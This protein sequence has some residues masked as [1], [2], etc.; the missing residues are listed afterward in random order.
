MPEALREKAH[1]NV[2]VLLVG[3][4]VTRVDLAAQPVD[5]VVV[6]LAAVLVCLLADVWGLD[7]D[8][9]GGL[10]VGIR[11]VEDVPEALHSGGGC[12]GG[13]RLRAPKRERKLA[14]VYRIFPAVPI[15]T[16]KF[17]HLIFYDKVNIFLSRHLD[18]L[19]RLIKNM[20]P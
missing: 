11:L 3:G 15:R 16:T 5:V 4:V 6:L 9:D 17:N 19:T 18:A 10:G 12:R 13:R 20:W 1:D 7:D 2:V 14:S 8:G